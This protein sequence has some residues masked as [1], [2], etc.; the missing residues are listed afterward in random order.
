LDDGNAIEKGDG[1]QAG[2]YLDTTPM[3]I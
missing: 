3:G 2:G 1:C